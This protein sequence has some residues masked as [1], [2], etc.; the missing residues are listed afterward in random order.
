MRFPV[1]RKVATSNIEHRF[2][3]EQQYTDVLIYLVFQRP[4]QSR[5]AKVRGKPIPGKEVDQINRH[6]LGTADGKA[7]DKVKNR[8]AP[9]PFSLFRRIPAHER[10]KL[11]TPKPEAVSDEFTVEIVLILEKIGS[12]PISAI[13]A[14]LLRFLRIRQDGHQTRSVRLWIIGMHNVPAGGRI[15][16]HPR[17][18][19]VSANNWQ[20]KGHSFQQ[21]LPE[22]FFP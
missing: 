15:Y 6:S 8:D 3:A 7:V 22:P 11:I 1:C 18:T 4:A 21:Y 2:P 10:A 20:S 19:N 16:E 17:N 5:S 9:V 14:H 12:H 13:S